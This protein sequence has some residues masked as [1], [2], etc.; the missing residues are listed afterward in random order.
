MVGVLF[1]KEF[2][3]YLTFSVLQKVKMVKFKLLFCQN[4]IEMT[5]RC[6]F[7]KC[8]TCGTLAIMAC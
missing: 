3:F 5:Y 7:L 6:V 8:H 2:S 1:V 4:Y